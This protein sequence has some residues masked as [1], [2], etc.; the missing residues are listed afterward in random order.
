MGLI[1]RI[2]LAAFAVTSNVTAEYD[3]GVGIADSADR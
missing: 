2:A 3:V 1:L